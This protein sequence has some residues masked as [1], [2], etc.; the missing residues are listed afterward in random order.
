MTTPK[1]QGAGGD[2]FAYYNSGTYASPTWVELKRLENFSYADSLP[3]SKTKRR[4]SKFSY[5]IPG[6]FELALSGNYQKT[7]ATDSVYS[8][9]RTNYR[10]KTVTEI[11]VADRPID[12][13]GA[14][15]VRAGYLV[16]KMDENQDLENP[17]AVALEF[18]LAELVDGSGVEIEPSDNTTS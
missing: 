11:A 1:T 10:A 18:Q 15:W 7:R 13:S 4:G 14:K 3:T 5:A 8:A 12:E 9:L 17:N 16:T 2:C 6:R